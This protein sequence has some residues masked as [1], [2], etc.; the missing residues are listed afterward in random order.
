MPVLLPV[1]FFL[2]ADVGPDDFLI[3]AHRACVEPPGPE[4]LAAEIAL[5]SVPVARHPDCALAFDVPDDAGDAVL[6]RNLDQDV[7]MVGHQVPFVDD[8]VLLPGKFVK[9]RAQLDAQWP[10]ELFLPVFRDKNDVVE[11][12]SYRV[13]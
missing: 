12:F 2:V 13:C 10:V 8:A 5:P 6:R 7:D 4:M 9:D 11:T 3:P 1:A